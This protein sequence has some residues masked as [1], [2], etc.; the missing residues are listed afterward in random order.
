MIPAIDEALFEEIQP[1]AR[2]VLSYLVKC[3]ICQEIIAELD[4]A[5]THMPIKGSMFLSADVHHGRPAPFYPE[6]DWLLIRCPICKWRPF[7][8]QDSV[9]LADGTRYQIP[10]DYYSLTSFNNT[11]D[12]AEVA[13][14]AHTHK[15]EGSNPSPAPNF[16]CS[17]CGKE[18]KN[19]NSLSQHVTAKHPTSKGGNKK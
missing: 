6:H 3:E 7:L 19:A 9:V 2:K 1:E 11:R 5:N 10:P 15:V 17:E 13:R 18:C 8:Q 12:S 14:V 4:I 16:V